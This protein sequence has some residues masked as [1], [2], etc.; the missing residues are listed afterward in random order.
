MQDD[1][2]EDDQPDV[3]ILQECGEAPGRFSLEIDDDVFLLTRPVNGEDGSILTAGLSLEQNLAR[4]TR[5]LRGWSA[6]LSY[7]HNHSR[8]EMKDPFT[9]KP[10][11]VEK[12]ARG[13]EKQKAVL[14]VRR[15][16]KPDNRS[17]KRKK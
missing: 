15:R 9:G 16:K 7:I 5:S 14:A 10:C 3:V 17:R 13:R 1:A 11:F 8:T 12:T 6:A 2:D 4:M